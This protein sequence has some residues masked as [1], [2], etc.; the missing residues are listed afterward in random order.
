MPQLREL[1]AAWDGEFTVLMRK[2]IS[3]HVKSCGVCD[4]ERRRLVSPT[5]LLGAAPV[6][7]PAPKWLREKTMRE[8]NWSATT[9]RWPVSPGC[10]VT[11]ARTAVG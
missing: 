10:R 11:P 4:E 2:R 6:M 9:P 1:L 5:A 8:C 3:R 7:I